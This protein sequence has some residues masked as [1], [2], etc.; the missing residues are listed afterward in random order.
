MII[1]WQWTG[2][3]SNPIKSLAKTNWTK[4]DEAAA[5]IRTGIT[6]I[7]IHQAWLLCSITIHHDRYR[8]SI[9]A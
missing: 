2:E 7:T 4:G 8:M 6:I 3:G 9:A 5:M 1:E